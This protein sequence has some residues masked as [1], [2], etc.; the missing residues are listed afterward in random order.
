MKYSCPPKSG[1]E[2]NSN[3]LKTKFDKDICEHY[4]HLR[5]IVRNINI[6]TQQW[7]IYSILETEGVD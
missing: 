3:T 1:S 4:S 6:I 2:R 7:N 5:K